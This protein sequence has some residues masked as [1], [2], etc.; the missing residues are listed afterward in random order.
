MQ[1]LCSRHA[2]STTLCGMEMVLQCCA[3]LALKNYP[4]MLTTAALFGHAGWVQLE[5]HQY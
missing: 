2:T 1:G 5:P 4:C 3:L